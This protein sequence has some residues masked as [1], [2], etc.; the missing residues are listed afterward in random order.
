ML[1]YHPFMAVWHVVSSRLEK[2]KDKKGKT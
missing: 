1:L 2:K